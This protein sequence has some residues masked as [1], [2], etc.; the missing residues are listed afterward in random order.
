MFLQIPRKYANRRLVLDYLV[1]YEWLFHHGRHVLK[2][3]DDVELNVVGAA[4]FDI[5]QQAGCGY[6]SV[7]RFRDNTFFCIS[8]VPNRPEWEAKMPP[9]EKYEQ[10]PKILSQEDLR[11]RWFQVY[12]P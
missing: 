12:D 8:L 2:L 9:R 10:I 5:R 7:V 4:G 6:T 3:T 11:P 1:T